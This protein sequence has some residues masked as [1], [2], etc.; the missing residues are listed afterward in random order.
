MYLLE[1]NVPPCLGTQTDNKRAEQIWG[2]MANTLVKDIVSCFILPQ[3]TSQCTGE[4]AA[5]GGGGAASGAACPVR[6]GDGDSGVKPTAH[7]WVACSG[8]EQL[9]VS[10]CA[11]EGDGVF[12]DGGRGCSLAKNEEAW[13]RFEQQ[14]A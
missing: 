12:M 1:V 13:L 3:C 5:R 10:F 9:P 14:H 2:E 6:D 8:L 7:G 11:S 4:G